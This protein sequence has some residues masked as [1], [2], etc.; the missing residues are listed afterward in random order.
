MSAPVEGT[1]GLCSFFSEAPGIFGGPFGADLVSGEVGLAE[2]WLLILE[3]RGT[4]AELVVMEEISQ[5]SSR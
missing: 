5:L 4:S 2:L 3:R 1:R